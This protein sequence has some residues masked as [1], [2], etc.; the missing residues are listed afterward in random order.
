MVTR[1]RR[2]QG[3]LD[4]ERSGIGL[5]VDWIV[6]PVALCLRIERAGYRMPQTRAPHEGERGGLQRGTTWCR[7]VLIVLVSLETLT[8][9][10]LFALRQ[11]L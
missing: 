5:M 11:T 6:Q 2:Y 3:V 8:N 7:T 4:G 1:D 10:E 9:Y